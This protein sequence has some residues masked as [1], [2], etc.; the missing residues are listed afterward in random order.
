MKNISVNGKI[1]ELPED[2]SLKNIVALYSGFGKDES[3]FVKLNGRI[4]NSIIDD[5]E[6]FVEDGDVLEIFPLIIG[7]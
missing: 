3:Y 2:N 5:E 6:V 4:I 1:K 7:G